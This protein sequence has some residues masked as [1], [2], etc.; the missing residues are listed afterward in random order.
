MISRWVSFIGLAMFISTLGCGWLHKR[1]VALKVPTPLPSLGETSFQT[2]S[3]QVSFS[4]VGGSIF[5]PCR[6]NNK[7]IR[8]I[9]DT[10]CNEVVW[11][12]W[13]QISGQTTGYN[14]IIVDTQGSSERAKEVVINQVSIGDY[15][16]NKL[17]TYEIVSE[18][19]PM[20]TGTARQHLLLG[21]STFLNTRL[22]IDY[23]KKILV[24]QPSN[25]TSQFQSVR[26]ALRFIWVPKDGSQRVGVPAVKGEINGKT[27]L[28]EID[29][30][31]NNKNIAVSDNLWESTIAKNIS[32]IRY[33][34]IKT[35]LS[36][37]SVEYTNKVTVRFPIVAGVCSSKITVTTPAIRVNS[38]TSGANAIIGT[39]ILSHYRT[40]IDYPHQTITLEP[41]SY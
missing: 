10:G 39:A 14:S 41:Y 9:L 20:Q 11:P 17:P 33:T 26:Y 6:F 12:E 16:V 1:Q 31:W 28:I 34:K 35:S 36:A 23:A 19:T 25:S 30:G 8:S 27:A 40:T 32:R 4:V 24:I 15:T 13:L 5:V 2:K 21:N 38:A 18:N 29:T 3:S 37:A 22:T 7:P